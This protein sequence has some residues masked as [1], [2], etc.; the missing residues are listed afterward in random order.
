MQFKILAVALL[1]STV[2]ADT[3]AAPAPTAPPPSP[4]FEAAVSALIASYI[5]SSILI[6]LGAAVQSAAAA[7]GVTGALPDIIESA[8]GA[9]APPTWLTA[10]PTEYQS[11]IA[12]LES[13][14]ESLK[15][16]VTATAAPSSGITSPASGNGTTLHTTKGGPTPTATGTAS[17]AASS[18]S[19]SAAAMPAVI[20]PGAAGILGLLGFAFAL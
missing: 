16:G 2:L 18:S 3:T 7:A 6:P 9:P 4:E 14:I 15:E 12:A 10:I 20:V 1:S 13:A 17:A 8:L 5:P 11:N 19:S